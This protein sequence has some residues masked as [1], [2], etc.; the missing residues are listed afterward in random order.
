MFSK[1]VVTTAILNNKN[2][3]NDYNPHELI[4][5]IYVIA[6]TKYA[7]CIVFYILLYSISQYL[8]YIPFASY[9]DFSIMIIL[10]IY[11]IMIKKLKSI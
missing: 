2:F 3:N 6:P 11:N 5:N 4:V 8:V 9:L 7:I 1:H 10:Y